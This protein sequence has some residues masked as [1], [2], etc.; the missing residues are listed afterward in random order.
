LGLVDVGAGLL[1]VGV[2]AWVVGALLGKGS[3]ALVSSGVGVPVGQRV[4]A[5]VDVGAEGVGVVDGRGGTVVV[6]SSL[7][8][9]FGVVGFWTTEV[10]GVAGALAAGVGR[11]RK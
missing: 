10:V 8:R 1:V 3:G 11:T 9:I 2:P 5:G 4:G 7:G 6:V